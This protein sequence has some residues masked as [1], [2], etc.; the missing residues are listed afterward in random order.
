MSPEKKKA[1][2]NKLLHN[3]I[4]LIFRTTTN[5]FRKKEE[6]EKIMRIGAYVALVLD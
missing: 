1:T 5:F 2:K 4:E 6:E 3:L